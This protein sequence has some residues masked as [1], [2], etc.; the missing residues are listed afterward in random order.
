MA[1][2]AGNPPSPAP[3]V[4]RHH[5]VLNA[6]LPVTNLLVMRACLDAGCNYI[7]LAS[8]A[9]CRRHPKLDDQLA[10]DAEFRAAGRLALLVWAPTPHHQRLCRLRREAPARQRDRD[11]GP[12]RRQLRLP[13]ARRVRGGVQSLGLHR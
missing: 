11:P 4:N 5:S 9:R 3:F 1:L 6:A 2:D 8:G 12:R 7:D 10:L 13:G